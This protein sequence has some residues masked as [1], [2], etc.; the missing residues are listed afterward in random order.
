MTET[1]VVEIISYLQGRG[2]RLWVDGGWGV[3]ALLGEQTRD[4]A[5]LDLAVE[6]VDSDLYEQA[7]AEAGFEFLY[8]DPA[9]D[10]SNGRHL[11]WV[12]KDDRGREIDVHL[13]DTS[14]TTMAPDGELV[15]GGI[16]YPVGSLTATGVVAGRE[17][18]CGTAQFQMAS[19]T[20]YEIADT[21]I[22]DIAALHRRFG[23]P[24]PSE[25]DELID[26]GTL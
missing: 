24:I 6:L 15:H 19:R 20:G 26:P 1:D 11:N 16:P 18:P 7:V 3:D 14:T 5:D 8:Y 2:V 12:V 9:N 21:D 10:D 22:H 23:L 17:V 25:Y 4:H 13:V